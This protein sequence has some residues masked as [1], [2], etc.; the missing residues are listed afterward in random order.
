MNVIARLENKLAYY[1]PAVHRF[2]HYTTRIPPMLLGKTFEEWNRNMKGMAMLL[3][4]LEQ[5]PEGSRKDRRN[6]KSE[7]ESWL[8]RLLHHWD[9]LEYWE[10]SRRPE[11]TYCL[12]DSTERPPANADLKKRAWNTKIKLKFRSNT[13][14][15]NFGFSGDYIYTYMRMLEQNRVAEAWIRIFICLRLNK[16]VI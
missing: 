12:T 10:E 4:C 15:G 9:R 13:L 16:Q 3:T 6:W 8:Y 1:N 11:E 7:E 5:S 2:N 14:H